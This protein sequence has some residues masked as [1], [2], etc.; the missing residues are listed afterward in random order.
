MSDHFELHSAIWHEEAEQ[1]NPYAA[2]R[3]LAY[4]YDVYGDV[5]HKSSWSEYMLLLFTGERP[6]ESAA[7]LLEKLAIALA[8]AGP[9]DTSVRAAMNGGV[10]GSVDAA[11]LIAA[12]AVGAGQYGGSH[13]VHLLVS[14]WQRLGMS[15]PQW[16]EYLSDPNKGYL[17]DVWS[18]IEHPPG[19]DPHGVTCPTPVIQTLS[20]LAPLSPEGALKWLSDHR[21]ELE[22][23]TGLPLSMSAVAAAAFVDLGFSS[24]QATMMYL[25]L[26][27][28]GAAVH[29]MEQEALGW[30]KFPAYGSAIHLS[31]DPGAYPLPDVSRFSL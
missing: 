30:K 2:K 26:R 6:S 11:S 9:R 7:A 21:C 10:G 27:L 23:H 8:N 4:G 25:M 29:A 31:D 28:P 1:D 14:A 5:I 15:V 13:E 12:L 19:F 20:I 16:S 18:R 3:C 22:R 24:T 17:E